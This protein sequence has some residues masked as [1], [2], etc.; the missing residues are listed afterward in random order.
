MKPYRLDKTAFSAQTVEEAANKYGYW[1]SQSYTERLKAAC[2]LNSA[3]FN[4]D[5]NNPH[6]LDRSA[7]KT[8]HRS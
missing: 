7:F 1:K 3:A 6:W 5:I 2:Y 4:F 8:R